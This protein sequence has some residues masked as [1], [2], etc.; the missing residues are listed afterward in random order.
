[1]TKPFSLEELVLRIEAVLRRT[2]KSNVV[3]EQQIYSFHTMEFN[4]RTQ[5]LTINGEG[6]KLTT[7][8]AQLL[9]LLCSHANNILDRNHV[10]KKI[11]NK[12][13]FYAA[14]SMDVYITKLRKL[15][16]PAH[17]L[18]IVNIHGKGYKLLVSEE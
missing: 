12:E 7:K 2:V 3:N 10:L 18:E 5:I 14:R 13:T 8:E 1:M 4:R 11:W 16:R 6:T 17:G 15:L 9:A